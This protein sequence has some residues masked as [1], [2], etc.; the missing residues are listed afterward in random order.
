MSKLIQKHFGKIAFGTGVGIYGAIKNSDFYS[1]IES[2]AL[3]T[4]QDFMDAFHKD[5]TKE[6][7]KELKKCGYLV[8]SGKV[9]RTEDEMIKELKQEA[10]VVEGDLATAF[11]KDINVALEKELL[12]IKKRLSPE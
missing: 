4:G 3:L 11:H 12:R 10:F 2:D 5:L 8:I 6:V 9:P 7:E 1:A